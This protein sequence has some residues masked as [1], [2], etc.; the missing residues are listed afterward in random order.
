MGGIAWSQPQLEEGVRENPV[1]EEIRDNPIEEEPLQEADTINDGVAD[2]DARKEKYK[3]DMENFKQ[4]LQKKR[5]ER[6]QAITKISEEM[7]ELRKNTDDLEKE[8]TLR[9]GLEKQVKALKEVSIVSN[10]MLQLRETQVA[11]LKK[12]LNNLETTAEEN[13]TSLRSQYENQIENIRKLRQLYEERAEAAARG[14]EKEMEKERAKNTLLELKL[15][16]HANDAATIQQ[17]NEKID[18]L[19]KKVSEKELENEELKEL[20]SS[21]VAECNNLTSQLTLIN[22]LFSNMLTG[23][24]DFDLLT[25]LL[26]DNHNLI[27]DLIANGDINDTAALLVNI[28]EKTY[29][30]QENIPTVSTNTK[31]EIA[32]NLPK[33]W[34]MLIELLSSHEESSHVVQGTS[35]EC[36]KHVKTPTGSRTVISVSQTFLRLKDLILEKN[37]LVKEVGR[38]KTL[39]GH[40]ENR[41]DQQEKRLGVVS[42]ELKKTWGIVSKLKVQHRQLHTHEKILRYELQH[43]R[44]MLTDLKHELE[45]CRETWDRAKEKNTQNEHDWELL[46]KEFALRKSRDTSNST[47]SG[48][49]DDENSQSPDI[50]TSELEYDLSDSQ[51]SSEMNSPSIELE[52]A[53]SDATVIELI[54]MLEF[55]DESQG[56]D[57]DKMIHEKSPEGCLGQGG[58]SEGCV[59][60][61]RLQGTSSEISEDDRV[62]GG[63]HVSESESLEGYE[64]L[65]ASQVTLPEA[66]ESLVSENPSENLADPMRSSTEELKSPENLADSIRS[67]SPVLESPENTADPMRSSSQT[68][69]SPENTADPMR[70]SVTVQESLENSA[71]PIRSSATMQ[72]SPETP[73]DP[74]RSSSKTLE[75]LESA[76]DSLR[77]PTFES[78][79][80]NVADSS[81]SSATS[82]TESPKDCTNSSRSPS[83]SSESP[84]HCPELR[85]LSETRLRSESCDEPQQSISS[86]S[87]DQTTKPFVKRKSSEE[88]L[89]ARAARLRRLEHQ[90][91]SLLNQMALTSLRS[92]TLST[93]LEELHE[94]YGSED[95]P[96]RRPQSENT[97]EEQTVSQAST[98]ESDSRENRLQ[99]M[100]ENCI[101]MLEN[102]A[103]GAE[104]NVRLENI[105]VSSHESNPS[106]EAVDTAN[107]CDNFVNESTQ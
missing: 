37:S 107:E 22:N 25:Q 42:S 26:Q 103:D 71:D 27:T 41:L 67:S 43:K 39:N 10:E 70:S 91:Q 24:M 11:E 68:L 75:S 58:S 72:E 93:R 81:I 14:H 101:K 46:R 36:Y 96:E 82:P 60:S 51:K 12:R 84:D 100:E 90:C 29:K 4:M 52:D 88:I 55:E 85:S 64:I 94:Q 56:Q 44:Q 89:E 97:T 6:K 95:R 18:E 8:R 65:D 15:E 105:C 98:A 66:T 38:L 17:L 80:V 5:E 106:N 92:D 62:T 30:K 28:A 99:Q 74:I 69:E 34:R 48:Y 40:L 32:T 1:E 57:D 49:E 35:D 76:T 87:A 19:E 79:S 23:D 59:D 21:L 7:N 31:Q 3:Q 61:E 16:E 9:I 54:D 63:F 104:L 33:V 53:A 102:V 77:S 2:Q 13:L 45:Y 78:S 47:E 86:S 50:S 73:A 83:V 20:R